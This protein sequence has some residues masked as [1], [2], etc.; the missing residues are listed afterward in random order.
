MI[1]IKTIILSLIL[2]LCIYIGN[3]I[4]KKYINRVE[5][6]KEMKKALNILQTKIR[7][8]YEPLPQ[9]FEY[10]SQNVNGDSTSKIF[11][12]S[13]KLMNKKSAGSA[14]KESLEST[15]TNFKYDDI[16]ALKT[17]GNLLGKTDSDGQISQIVLV[18]N[19]LDTQIEDAEIEKKKY[20]KMYKTLGITIGLGLVVVLI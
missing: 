20:V 12:N 11:E 1:L 17:L 13:S 5:D 6:L 14:W 3:T 2:I 19:M 10:I 9:V 15:K 18:N 7:Y 8:S 4:S 16:N